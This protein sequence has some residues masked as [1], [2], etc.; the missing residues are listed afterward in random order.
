[1]A[2]KCE[3]DEHLQTIKENRNKIGKQLYFHIIIYRNPFK[4]K[5]IKINFLFFFYYK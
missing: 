2:S 1:M 3:K 4:N 5:F